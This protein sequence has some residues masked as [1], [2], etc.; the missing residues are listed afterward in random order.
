MTQ[1]AIAMQE[2]QHRASRIG[3]NGSHRSSCASKVNASQ[4]DTHD[5]AKSEDED[6]ELEEVEEGGPKPPKTAKR[7]SLNK[8]PLR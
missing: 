8:H 4:D 1:P 2:C 6:E 3:G 7:P 5:V